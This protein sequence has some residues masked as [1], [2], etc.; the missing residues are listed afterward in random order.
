MGQGRDLRSR[1][2][3]ILFMFSIDHSYLILTYFDAYPYQ[4]I[5]ASCLGISFSNIKIN[6]DHGNPRMLRNLNA[7]VET[8]VCLS[9]PLLVQIQSQTWIKHDQNL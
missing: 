9:W 8:R 3:Q 6:I 1:G 4:T 7:Y 2:T 5:Q